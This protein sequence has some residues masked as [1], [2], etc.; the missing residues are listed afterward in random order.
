MTE[1]NLQAAVAELQARRFDELER[2]R[3][4]A[5]DTEL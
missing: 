4:Q 1:A 3:V 2:K 5:L